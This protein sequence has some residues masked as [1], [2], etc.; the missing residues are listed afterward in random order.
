MDW[1]AH[2]KILIWD[3][4]N[5]CMVGLSK[6]RSDYTR[7]PI[8]HWQRIPRAWT[9]KTSRLPTAGDADAQGCVL[10]LDV[11]TGV[12][13]IGWNNPTLTDRAIVAWQR[14]PAAPKVGDADA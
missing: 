2:G 3:S 1:D 11:Y 7:E 8:T 12:R 5:G 10:V 9:P 14:L 13:M 4:N 6:H